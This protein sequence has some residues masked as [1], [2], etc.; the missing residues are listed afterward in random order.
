M[1]P[2]AIH[3]VERVPAPRVLCL[4]G[5]GSSSAAFAPQSTSSPATLRLLAWDA[6]GYAQVGGPERSARPGR[7]RRRGGRGD[8]ASA[9]TARARARRLLGRRHRRPAGA[10]PPASW[11]AAWCSPTPPAAPG[12]RAEQAA[13]MRARAA[14]LAR[15]GRRRLRRSPGPA[16][17][18]PTAAPDRARRNGRGRPWRRRSG[19]RA[20]ATPPSRW[21]PPTSRPS[22][23]TIDT[24]TLVLC[25]AEDTVT[26]VAESQAWPAAS[27]T[28]CSSPSG[29]PDTSRTR[30]PGGLQR[31]GLRLHPHHRTPLPLKPAAQRKERSP[32]HSTTTP[33]TS[34]SS[35]TR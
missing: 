32:C 2:N 17:A 3:V 28:P 1:N 7:L 23:P 21:P 20:T 31:L 29:A 12:G 27:R 13:G 11:S 33:P 8:P 18:S 15:A 22:C 5:I 30:R 9:S 6:P 16:T 10:A 34:R 26:G 25:G 4:H 35:P 24:P 19:C 14:E